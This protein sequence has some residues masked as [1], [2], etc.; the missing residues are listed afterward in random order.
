MEK[1]IKLSDYDVNLFN[2]R[3]KETFGIDTITSD[4]IW[5]IV[6][7][8]DQ[9]EMRHGTYDD[10]TP[11]GIYLRTVTEVREAPKYRQWIKERYV[12]ERL[13]VI[14]ESSMPEL[15]ATKVSYEP[16]FVFNDGRGDYLPPNLEVAFI[17]IWTIYDA[18]YGTKNLARYKDSFDA[19]SEDFE[20]RMKR[21]E[22]MTNYMYGEGS[23]FSSGI[24]T[25]ETVH[26]PSNYK[27]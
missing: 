26:M 19:H 20:V 5:R 15:P 7:S 12:L 17:T 16:I 24:R 8:E 11:S 4:P 6:W 10:I 3:L 14:P 2:T 22:E 21:I 18:Q 23:S 1:P 27:G 13:V 25:G 9:F